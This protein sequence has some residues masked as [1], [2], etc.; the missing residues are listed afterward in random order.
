MMGHMGVGI[1]VTDV[2]CRDDVVFRGGE[3]LH[4]Q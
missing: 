4:V 3:R 1:D 2:T